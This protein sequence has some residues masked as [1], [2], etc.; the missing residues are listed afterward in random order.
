MA[1]LS[2]RRADVLVGL[3][4]CLY[5][6]ASALLI[7][8]FG[9]TWDEPENFAIGHKY[10]HFYRTGHLDFADRQPSIPLPG[11]YEH[12]TVRTAP[13]KIWPFANVVSAAA[14]DL[15]HGWLGLVDPISAH[16]LPIPLFLALLAVVLYRFVRRHFGP[17]TAVLSVLLLLTFPRLFGHGMNNVKDVPELALFGITLM[18]FADWVLTGKR[19]LLAAAAITFGLALATKPDAVL[20]PLIVLLWSGPGIV[21]ELRQRRFH[22]ETVGWLAAASL[23]ALVVMLACYPPVL[24]SLAAGRNGLSFL[25]DQARYALAKASDPSTGWNLYAPRQLLYTTPP[26][27]L[28]SLLMGL[29]WTLSQWRRRPHLLVLLWLFVPILRHTLP[30]VR[31]YDAL[32]HLLSVLL[33]VAVITAAGVVYAASRLQARLPGRAA[34]VAPL[35]LSAV[36]TLPQLIWLA[37]LHPFQTTYYNVVVGGLKGAQRRRLPEACDYWLNSFRAAGRW[38][39]A[40]AEAGAAYHGFPR[41]RL[42]RYSVR[43]ADLKQVPPRGRNQLPRPF[44][45]NLYVVRVPRSWPGR[46]ELDRRVATWPV[47]FRLTRQGGEIVTIVHN[48]AAPSSAAGSAPHP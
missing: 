34:R 38:L 42:L 21:R 28:L 4:V 11:F 24:Q 32:R 31:H 36:V 41:N 16:H 29:A 40:H 17:G 9:I 14:C 13:E 45:D 48:P 27:V 20:I 37:A 5:L 19:R 33:P 15:L 23:L 35:A 1:R 46:A 8:D 2:R 18:W 30:G 10:L 44:P 39:D 47:V 12:P 43:R 6:I 22:K 25:I 7:S 3:I 26:L